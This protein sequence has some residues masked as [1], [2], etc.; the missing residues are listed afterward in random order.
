MFKMRKYIPFLFI[1]LLSLL[2]NTGFIPLPPKTAV[3]SALPADV[4]PVPYNDI[5]GHWAEA[6]ISEMYL[7]D[8]MKGYP[9]NTFKPNNPV[10]KI[11]AVVMLV[12]VMGLT[13]NEEL[14][15][16]LPY[17]QETFNIPSWANGFVITALNERLL[18]YNELETIGSQKPLSRQDAA[19]LVIR[20]LDL[21]NE[22]EKTAAR[23]LNFTDADQIKPEFLGYISLAVEKG[24]LKG[25]L[26]GAF[27]PLNPVSRAELAVLFSKADVFLPEH[28]REIVGTFVYTAANGNPEL[29][30][31]KDNNLLT[32][33]M[34]EKCLLFRDGKAVGWEDLLAGDNVKVINNSQEE[35]VLVLATSAPK[36]EAKEISFE[37]L[38]LEA[39]TE[40]VQ[41]FVNANKAAEDCL[42]LEQDGY[43]YVLA[44]RG[45]KPNSGYSVEISKITGVDKDNLINL[46]VTVVKSDPK[47]GFFYNP[48][49]TYRFTLAKIPLGNNELGQV[50]FVDETGQMLKQIN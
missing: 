29:T 14:A 25:N 38:K 8:I 23:Q 33:T 17:L 15:D 46:E 12:R 13:P 21:T 48:V 16:D 1:I 30:L 2:L 28:D 7:K 19:R 3:S 36:P 24:L 22:A 35:G 34:T 9:D 11:Q 40:A 47:P 39:E 42:V 31:T 27:Q 43:L 49:L 6:A 50:T 20:A 10:T 32:I 41:N 18:Y 26:K 37:T 5:T 45:E 4:K 44:A